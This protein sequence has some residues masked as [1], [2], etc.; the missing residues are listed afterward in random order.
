M[1][2]A[3][4]K[5][6]VPQMTSSG[7]KNI[8]IIDDEESIRF[9]F[10]YL[11][12]DQGYRVDVAATPQEALSCLERSDYDLIFLDILLGSHSGISTLKKIK[13]SY[14]ATPVIMVTGAP[15]NDSVSEAIGIGAVAYLPKPV[16]LDTLITVTRK[17]L[18]A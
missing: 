5:F 8:L 13:K 6:Y 1:I 11:L 15:D 4:W 10:S 12:A 7:Q 17:T 2:D 14:P 9:T 3:A 18:N 16:R